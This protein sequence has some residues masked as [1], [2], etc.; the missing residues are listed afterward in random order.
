M[1]QPTFEGAYFPQKG[2]NMY[3]AGD[4]KTYDKIC[5]MKKNASSVTRKVT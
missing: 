5:W 2:G 1:S 3:Q 4:K